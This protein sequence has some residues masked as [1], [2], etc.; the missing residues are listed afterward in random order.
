MVGRW[1]F[2]RTLIS[3]RLWLTAFVLVDHA[4]GGP[5]GGRPADTTVTVAMLLK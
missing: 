3:A 5:F 1:P 4:S 2:A